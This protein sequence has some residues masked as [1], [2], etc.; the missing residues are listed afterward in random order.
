MN[1][2]QIFAV[3]C[4]VLV[5]V[6]F[7]AQWE[8]LVAGVAAT[9]SV[10]GVVIGFLLRP[11]T[12]VFSLE[13][14][15]VQF[16]DDDLVIDHDR[17]AVRVEVV[18]LW[19]L[20]IPTLAGIGFLLVTSASGTTW[21][22]SLFELL[23]RIGPVY[24]QLMRVPLFLVFALVW[25]W[26]SERWVLHKADEACSAN[27]VSESHVGITYSFIDKA[28]EY[29]GAEAIAF[30]LMRAMDLNTM[31]VYHASNP[32]VSKIGISL[33]FHRFKVISRGLTDLDEETVTLRAIATEPQC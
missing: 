11:R 17:I 4:L 24:L 10:A 31:V 20:F 19:L 22:F 2:W 6:C 13:T 23:E 1:R 18:R 27:N 28:G 32:S 29:Y 33:L 3:G 15:V 30:N 25:I 21:H 16:D 9:A 7:L 8:M 14:T 26:V 12:Q 5:A